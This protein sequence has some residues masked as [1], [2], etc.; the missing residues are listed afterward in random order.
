MTRI[1]RTSR[2]VIVSSAVLLAATVLLGLVPWRLVAAEPK[3]GEK[4]PSSAAEKM[5]RKGRAL[6]RV[7]PRRRA[8]GWLRTSQDNCRN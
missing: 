8:Q 4:A 1:G 7:R 2:R 6:P 5:R 3:E